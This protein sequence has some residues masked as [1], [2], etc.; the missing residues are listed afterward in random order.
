MSQ[1]NIALLT[2]WEFA[3]FSISPILSGLKRRKKNERKA[4]KKYKTVQS[5]EKLVA[6]LFLQTVGTIMLLT[7][8]QSVEGLTGLGWGLCMK[9]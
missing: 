5:E 8:V 4:S 6:L 1:K 3:D 9:G 2:I 7:A